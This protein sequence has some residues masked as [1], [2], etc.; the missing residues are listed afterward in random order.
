MSLV[1][2]ALFKD[3]IVYLA[4]SFRWIIFLLLINRRLNAIDVI[5]LA[6]YLH[7]SKSCIQKAVF[8]EQEAIL[9]KTG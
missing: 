8:L 9:L 2:A 6:C 7:F 3:A 4:S 5:L 1:K